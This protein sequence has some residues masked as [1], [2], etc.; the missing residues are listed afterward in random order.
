MAG[1][2]GELAGVGALVEG[3]EDEGEAGVVAELVEERTEG[4][5]EVSGLGN[6]GALVAAE[7][8]VEGWVVVADGAGV[9]LHGEAVVEAHGRPSR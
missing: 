5:D 9:E 4:V 2:G 8:G 3:E 7:A 1:E 6:V